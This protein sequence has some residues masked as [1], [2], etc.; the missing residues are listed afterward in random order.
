MYEFGPL[1]VS[2]QE[3]LADLRPLFPGKIYVGADMRQGMGL[4][5]VLNL[6][7]IDQPPESVGTILCL[8]TLGHAEHPR[9]R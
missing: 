1:Q 3:A 2:G 9:R 8:D 6:Y 4:N 5:Q 7:T